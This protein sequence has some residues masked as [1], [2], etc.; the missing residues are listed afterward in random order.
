VPLALYDGIRK[1]VWKSLSYSASVETCPNLS[2]TLLSQKRVIYTTEHCVGN[3]LSSAAYRKLR[4]YGRRELWAGGRA[5]ILRISEHFL[6]FHLGPAIST[7][8]SQHQDFRVNTFRTWSKWES[9]RQLIRVMWLAHYKARLCSS[10]L[11]LL[12]LPSVHLLRI[13][14][15][16]CRSSG[17]GLP[18]SVFA[19]AWEKPSVLC[20]TPQDATTWITLSSEV[21]NSQWGG[22]ALKKLNISL[23]SIAYVIVRQRW[24][25]RKPSRPAH[26]Y[27]C[28]IL[29]C[30]TN[31]IFSFLL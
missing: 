13:N 28:T 29:L 19:N 18:L 26:A 12:T 17:Q 27:T 23:S 8:L 4:K 31:G 20:S 30:H 1:K 14:T 6:H 22:S 21:Q 25:E 2:I 24:G 7:L 11:W 9:R 10:S 5:T 3:E 16:R 15:N